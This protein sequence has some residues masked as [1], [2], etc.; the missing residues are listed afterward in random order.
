MFTKD[1]QVN[2]EFKNK[3]ESLKGDIGERLIR[4]YLEKEEQ[5][6]LY[7]AITEKA[8]CF[9]YLAYKY[10]K[11]QYAVEIKTK[12]ARTY[13]PD[14]G[15]DYKYYTKYKSASEELK[16]RVLVL[17]VD[18]IKGTVYG[19]YLDELDK[20]RTLKIDDKF[21]KYPQIHNG[22][23]YFPLDVMKTF[24][25]INDTYLNQLKL[26]NQAKKGDVYE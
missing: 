4:D 22:I 2:F 5:V 14:T 7:K 11:F 16:L 9:D 13:Y 10:N 3:I 19:E 24:F 18:E 6:V 12:P 1:E 15:F 20:P 8:H 26:I 25:Y 17:F 23:I 21:T